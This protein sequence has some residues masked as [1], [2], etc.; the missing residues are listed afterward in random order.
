MLVLPLYYPMQTKNTTYMSSN[1]P[2]QGV[3]GCVVMNKTGNSTADQ[4]CPFNGTT[5]GNST[6]RITGQLPLE[7]LDDNGRSNITIMLI[8][9]SGIE[10]GLNDSIELSEESFKP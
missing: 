5:S 9:S 2:P 10:V 6:N 4:Y 1:P 8:Y 7:S 3:R